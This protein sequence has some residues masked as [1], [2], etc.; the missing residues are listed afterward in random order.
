[1]R[2]DKYLK[3]SRLIKRRTVANEA[4]DNERVTVNGS[5]GLLRREGGRRDHH[6][7]RSEGPVGGGAVGGRQRG[8]GRRRRHVPGDHGQDVII[9]PALSY[10]AVT[11]CMRG[12][13]FWHMI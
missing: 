2:L 8:Q 5:P 9:S 11:L 7:L 3:V 12:C 1:M 10:N 4:C 6:S 13:F